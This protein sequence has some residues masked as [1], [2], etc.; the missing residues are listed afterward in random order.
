M[1]IRAFAGVAA[2][3]LM[4]VAGAA[5]QAQS[6]VEYDSQWSLKAIGVQDAWSRRYTGAGVTVGVIDSGLDATHP[7]F[8]GQL[9]PFSLDVFTGGLGVID[10]HSHGTHVAGTI[11]AA[12]NG[13][14]MVGV[15]Y[16][17]QLT[18]L[19]FLD[20]Q[21]VGSNDPMAI[22][23]LYGLALDNGVR[24]FNNS[25]GG[26]FLI[27]EAEPWEVVQ[28]LGA[29]EIAIYQ[30]AAELD[31]ILVWATG[32]ESLDQPGLQASLPYYLPELQPHWIAVTAT[33]NR[34][35]IASYANR[36]GLA[37]AWCMAA[38]GGDGPVGDEGAEEAFI[39]STIPDAQ[40]GAKAGTSMAAPHVTGAVAIARQM[41]PQAPAA[42]LSRLTLATATDLGAPGVDEIYGWGLLNVANLAATRDAEAA[43]IFA[44]AAWAGREA[45]AQV[46][47]LLAVQS[48]RTEGRRA[49]MT[50][51]GRRAEHAGAGGEVEALTLAAGLD[52]VRRRDMSLGM[53]LYRTQADV[54]PDAMDNRA[55]T[56]A[57][58]AAL[59]GQARRGRLF[60]RA[61]VAAETADQEVWRR[62]IPGTR[63]T[64]LAGAGLTG[65]SET[66]G[67]A[68]AAEIAA[69]AAFVLPAATVRPLAFVRADHQSVEG[70]DEDG[71][72][73]FSLV[74][75]DQS[76]T[77]YAAGPGVE[78]ALNPA[79]VGSAEVRVGAS[80]R[81]AFAWGDDDGAYET[82]LLGAPVTAGLPD[83]AEGLALSAEVAAHFSPVAQGF[84]RLAYAD[85]DRREAWGLSAGFG[86]AF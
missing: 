3:C 46:L 85:G 29:E 69:G 24:L 79:W 67:A 10:E 77:Q 64:V 66:S 16:D 14:G 13:R 82:R 62:D 61:A 56:R 48:A 36:C 44:D 2:A 31:S 49:W 38:P 81:Y 45:R 23:A 65:R 22:P 41:Y 54:V 18:I 12:R 83:S 20:G 73:V 53:A 58:G 40:L 74:A 4:S 42:A 9:T 63:G 57:V 21:N 59:Y 5:A 39:I 37:A 28:F 26:G 7:E 47:D 52:L 33:N 17:A 30:R 76:L 84:V 34:G 27:P 15:A 75:A 55:Q 25:W 78:L 6:F 32:N 11:A 19:R 70:F 8:E 51:A 80:A 68:A 50:A 35:G 72:D 1:S 86:V 60:A 43:Q 71:A